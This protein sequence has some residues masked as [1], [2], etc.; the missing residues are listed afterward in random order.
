MMEETYQFAERNKDVIERCS[1]GPLQALPGTGVWNYALMKG[2]VSDDMEWSRLGTSY[3]THDWD[4]FPFLGEQVTR[5]EFMNMWTRFHNLAKEINYVGQLRSMAF[6]DHKKWQEIQK[7]EHELASLKGSRLVRW[8]NR[9]R[10]LR[11]SLTG[12]QKELASKAASF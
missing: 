1:V 8:A 5:E 2:K 4:R 10:G 12:G 3:E 6:Q 9:L 11:Q 7:L